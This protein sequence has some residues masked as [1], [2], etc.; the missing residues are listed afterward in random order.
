MS[1]LCFD[2]VNNEKSMPLLNYMEKKKRRRKHDAAVGGFRAAAL[3]RRSRP[4]REARSQGHGLV[5]HMG[6]ADRQRRVKLRLVLD[7]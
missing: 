1:A 2:T 5:F 4:E 6:P 3:R 7:L